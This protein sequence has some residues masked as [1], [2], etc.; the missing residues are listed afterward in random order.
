LG[1]LLAANTAMI[2]DSF[3]QDRQRAMMGLQSA[4]SSAGVVLA[5]IASG[6]LVQAHWR[7]AFVVFLPAFA[8]LPFLA[9][10]PEPPRQGRD[11]C[12]VCA[13]LPFGGGLL[14]LCL[15][16]FMVML[17][18]NIIPTQLPFFMEQIGIRQTSKMGPL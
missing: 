15:F 1:G 4:F 16:G 14:V 3:D 10:C 8:I 2:A 12:R 6:W 9:T 13:R 18:F 7:L 5:L 17:A 11:G